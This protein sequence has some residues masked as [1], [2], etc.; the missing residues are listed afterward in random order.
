MLV[1]KLLDARAV[2]SR[3]ALTPGPSPAAG[4]GSAVPAGAGSDFVQDGRLVNPHL[5]GDGGFDHE[6]PTMERI[7]TPVLD[8]GGKHVEQRRAVAMEIEEHGAAA[9]VV[10]E[11]VE[12]IGPHRLEQRMAGRDPFQGRIAGQQGLVEDDLAVLPTQAAEAGFLPIADGQ[13]I[14][15]HLA[16][17]KHAARLAGFLGHKARLGGGLHE[18]RLDDLRHQPPFLGLG[19]L[20]DDGRQVQILLGQALQGDFR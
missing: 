11:A 20:A 3:K 14:A 19:R 7:A 13:Q 2:G 16:D 12:A 5:A 4:E 8:R 17:A 9:Q 6:Q 10:L 15:R 18:E 1:E